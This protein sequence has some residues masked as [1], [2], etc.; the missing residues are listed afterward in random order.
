VAELFIFQRTPAW[1]VPVPM[2][3]DDVPEGLRWLLRHVPHYAH[4]YRFWTFWLTTDGLLPA[5]TVDESWPHQDRSVSMENDVLRML[6]DGYMRGQFGDRPDL[7]EK[8]IPSYP[9]ASKRML[10]DN[11]VWASALKRDNVHLITEPIERITPGGVVTKD[12]VERRA[13]VLILGTG[14][15]A[16]R[17]MAP[18]KVV[19]RNGIDLNEQW[20]GDARAY[21]GIVVPNFPNFFMLYGPNTNIVVN[22]SITYFSEC[23]VQY[24]MGCLRMLLEG[25]QRALDCKMDVHDAYNRRID[26]ANAKRAWGVG[27]VSTWYKNDRGHISQN[28][29]FNVIEYWQQTREPAREDFA[30]L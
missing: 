5:A 11:G 27:S 28:W 4:W 7:L 17:F 15:L 8:V 30:F 12:G 21:M 20:D 14:F 10:L 22:G 29:P 16:S 19:G 18:M 13:D 26:E 6:L 24:V 25:N 1:F 9:P 2:Y 23:E 3:H